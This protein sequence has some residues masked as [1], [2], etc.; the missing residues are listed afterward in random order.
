MFEFELFYTFKTEIEKTIL[1]R[2]YDQ[3][4]IKPQKSMEK[5]YR[6][7]EIEIL[8]SSINCNVTYS[9]FYS[10][11]ILMEMMMMMMNIILKLFSNSINSIEKFEPFLWLL[12]T[13]TQKK[14]ELK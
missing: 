4:K 8:Y 3:F 1:R 11:C 5:L 10:Y 7:N 2:F 9:H 6:R 14:G 12:N 13:H